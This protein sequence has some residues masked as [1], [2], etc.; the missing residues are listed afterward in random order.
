VARL[1]V[2]HLHKQLAKGKDETKR[3]LILRLLAEE[4]AKL[5]AFNSPQKSRDG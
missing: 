5:T 2:E 1:N 3:K 4:K